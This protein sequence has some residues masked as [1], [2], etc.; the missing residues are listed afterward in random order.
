MPRRIVRRRSSLKNTANSLAPLIFGMTALMRATTGLVMAAAKRGFC[1]SSAQSKVDPDR[2][3]PEIRWILDTIAAS[4]SP[5]PEL[6]AFSIGQT[7]LLAG[8]NYR[9]RKLSCLYLSNGDMRYSITRREP[10]LI[11]TLTAMPGARLTSRSSIRI[12]VRSSETRAA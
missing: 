9:S 5:R 12:C 1:R 4:P 6:F 11:S 7:Q 2:G 8:L 3:R 10:V